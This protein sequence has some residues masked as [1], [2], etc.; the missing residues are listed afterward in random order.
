MTQNEVAKRWINQSKESGRAS[1]LFFEGPVIYSWGKHFPIARL[2]P[3][4]AVLFNETSRSNSTSNHQG[5]V[6]HV[7]KEHR[8]FSVG[9]EVLYA[10]GPVHLQDYQRRIANVVAN[11]KRKRGHLGFYLEHVQRLISEANSFIGY[12][13]LLELKLTLPAE[14]P[15]LLERATKMDLGG[16]GKCWALC[17]QWRLRWDT[18]AATLKEISDF[19]EP[20]RREI[21]LAQVRQEQQQRKHK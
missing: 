11:I 10:P 20:C 7:A 2:L 9:M 3:C 16:I 6:R 12:F 4:G 21:R 5:V 13:G 18:P 19:T 14:W 17:R 8:I 15:E 1:A